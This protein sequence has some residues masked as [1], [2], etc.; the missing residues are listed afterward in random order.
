MSVF[1]VSAICLVALVYS[2]MFIIARKGRWLFVFPF[3]MVLV[4]YYL[5][6]RHMEASAKTVLADLSIGL[7]VII[8][9]LAFFW[10]FSLLSEPYVTKTANKYF[11]LPEPLRHHIMS[12]LQFYIVILSVLFLVF[13]WRWRIQLYGSFTNAALSMYSRFSEIEDTRL[14]ISG[15]LSMLLYQATS[16]FLS[17]RFF[18]VVIGKKHQVFGFI[19]F[20]CAVLLMTSIATTGIRGRTFFIPSM[21]IYAVFI[22]YALQGQ[23]QI[24]FK[25]RMYAV[26]LCCL[27]VVLVMTLSS[28]RGIRY[29]SFDEFVNDFNNENLFQGLYHVLLIGESEKH[30]GPKTPA[31]IV[32]QSMD[33]Y[34]NN[35]PFLGL[36]YTPYTIIANPVPRA[37][38]DSKPMGFGRMFVLEYYGLED[39]KHSVGAGTF[40]EG[41]AAYGYVG[42]I[43]YTI[44]FATLVGMAT[45]FCVSLLKNAVFSIEHWIFALHFL[46]MSIL[47]VRG[48][49]LSAWAQTVY[50]LVVTIMCLFTINLVYYTTLRRRRAY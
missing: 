36:Y 24:R 27:G 28:I 22:A 25:S 4:Q 12:R 20:I 17:Y 33:M 8:Y 29:D 7:S 40:G 5:Y 38:W 14:N 23:V 16:I 18:Q 37:L 35:V 32:A 42:G 47:F 39:S 45:R 41:Y 9:F 10:G 1:T 26:L 48:D 15:R 44:L 30:S 46:K 19:D 11:L 34:G 50:P 2:T 31:D 43:A 21:L 3:T 13:Y 6:F 49:M